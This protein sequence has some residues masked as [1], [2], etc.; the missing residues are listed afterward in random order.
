MQGRRTYATPSNLQMHLGAAC[1]FLADEGLP[2]TYREQVVTYIL[3]LMGQA[4]ALAPVAST[5]VDP[6]TGQGAYVPGAAN[7][8]PTPGGG[9]SA[10]HAD[11]FTS[12]GL[13]HV[14]RALTDMQGHAQSKHGQGASSCRWVIMRHQ[15]AA[16]E[17]RPSSSPF[18]V[19][20][21]RPFL[22]QYCLACLAAREVS[23]HAAVVAV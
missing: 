7:G 9:A 1:R 16:T 15:V 13:S 3:N 5:N 21:K 4:S 20:V 19:R 12:E 10:S 14:L 11:P 2:M 23:H 8:F 22:M 6:F 18:D 17:A